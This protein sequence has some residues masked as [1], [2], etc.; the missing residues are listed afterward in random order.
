MSSKTFDGKSNTG[1]FQE[2]LA[3]AISN[4]IQSTGVADEHITWKLEEV[5]GENG[6]IAGLNNITV[7]IKASFGSRR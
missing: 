6:S 2:A 1:N 4:A 7:T 3:D 5:K